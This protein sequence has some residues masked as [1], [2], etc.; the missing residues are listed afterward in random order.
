MKKNEGD[1]KDRLEIGIILNFDILFPYSKKFN[2]S[3]LF[4]LV[5]I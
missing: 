1:G 2:A 3:L 4:I 5:Y